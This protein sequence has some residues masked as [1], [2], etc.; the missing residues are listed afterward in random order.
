[1]KIRWLAGSLVVACSCAGFAQGPVLQTNVVMR[2][3]VDLT[4]APRKIIH[5]EFTLPVK[6]GPLTLLYPKWIPGEHEP[7]GPINDFTGLVITANGQRLAWVRDD[8]N[9]F[10]FHVTVPQG[11]SSIDVK[12]D[13]L[14]TAAATGFSAGASTSANLAML[15]WNE[16]VLY[17]DGLK[18]G[19]VEVQAAVK[20]PVGWQFGTALT[21]SSEQNGLVEFE[22]VPL[23]MLIDSPLLAGRY[24]KEIP[25]ATDVTPKHYLD[26]AADA[27]EDLE[28]KD[29]TLKAFSKLVTEAGALYKSRHYNSYHFLVTLS[30]QVAHF[31]LEHHQ[32]SDDRV[33]ERTFLDDNLSYLEADLLPHEYTH[34]WNGKYRRPAGL[35]HDDYKDPMIGNLLW[36]YEGL[37]DYLGNVLAARS[38]IET[39]DQFRSQLASTAAT[40][41]N[42]PGRTWRDLQ[43][44]ATSAQILYDTG[45]GWD[46]WRRGVDYYPEGE[47]LWLDVDTTIRR[48]THDKKSL[49]DFLARFEGVGGNT[50]PA[51]VPYDFNDVVTGLNA[52]APYDWA[53]FLRER[54]TSK[55]PNAPLEGITQGGYRLVYTDVPGDYVNAQEA[56]TGDALGWWAVGINVAGDGHISDVLMG[57]PAD[58]AGLG[59]GMQMVAVNG[60]QYTPQALGMAITAAKGTTE[61]IELI[62]S[63]TGYYKVLKVDY[64]GGLR[65]PHLERVQGTPDYLDEILKPM[66]K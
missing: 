62:V 53:S 33:S 2:L 60:R 52:V 46:N 30:D 40:M 43:D 48:L 1:M 32:S 18:P 12:D 64:H 13:F 59:P 35:N 14:A 41:D 38:G 44:T 20:L 45:E 5:A 29:D 27:P 25:L 42:R 4:D 15:S 47:L 54:L 36:V 19:D 9:M 34:S 8:V 28:V 61:P 63:N 3:T 31:G 55:S 50:G 51:V 7:D 6:P 65:F 23:N 56:S 21:K 22:P 58:K 24:F 11:V 66:T 17:P 57:S 16:V 10:A 49:N 26:M 39:D 37:T